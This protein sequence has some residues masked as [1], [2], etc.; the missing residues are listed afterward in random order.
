MRGMGRFV[1]LA[2]LVASVLPATPAHAAVVASGKILYTAVQPAP[3]E[4]QFVQGGC[5]T[6]ITSGTVAVIS[7]KKYAGRTMTLRAAAADLNPFAAVPAVH[8]ST[9]ATCDANG[10]ISGKA[11]GGASTGRPLVFRASGDHITLLNS[12]L[13]VQINVGYTLTVA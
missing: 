10:I 4:V 11:G 7:V 3:E 5:A 2:V 1:G 9:H 6:N 8:M 12:T 13:T